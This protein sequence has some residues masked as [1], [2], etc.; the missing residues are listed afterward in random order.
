MNDLARQRRGHDTN[1]EVA[2]IG[3]IGP[4]LLGGNPP[5][6]AVTFIS[7][8][9]AICFYHRQYVCMPCTPSDRV[10]IDMSFLFTSAVPDS[11]IDVTGKR[12]LH[13]AILRKLGMAVQ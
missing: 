3:L 1:R 12:R 5:R 11:S 10:P 6:H 9:E 4:Q 2:T 13:V 7:T 8:P